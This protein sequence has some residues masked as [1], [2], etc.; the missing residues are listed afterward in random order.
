M[1]AAITPIITPIIVDGSEK[2]SGPLTAGPATLIGFICTLLGVMLL[3]MCWDMMDM[4]WDE[5]TGTIIAICMWI[6]CGMFTLFGFG[7]MVWGMWH[8]IF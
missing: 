3:A 8:L 7:M 6:L 5:L 4:L 1:I 2:A